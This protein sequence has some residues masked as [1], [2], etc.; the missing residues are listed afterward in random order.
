MEEINTFNPNEPSGPEGPY[1]E[2]KKW[3]NTAL[4]IIKAV[5]IQ[6]NSNLIIL[7]T[8]DPSSPLSPILPITPSAPYTETT[9]YLIPFCALI[10][11]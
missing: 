5:G 3:K 10:F 7:L 9:Q 8:S 11:S 2:R 6:V 4:S 1:G